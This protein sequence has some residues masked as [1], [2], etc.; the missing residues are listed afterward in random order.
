MKNKI[1]T[2]NF[3]FQNGLLYPH[4]IKWVDE[5]IDSIENETLL[6]F[7]PKDKSALKTPFD[8][9]GAYVLNTRVKIPVS[10]KEWLPVGCQ[11]IH[12]SNSYEEKFVATFKNNAY[13]VLW[14]IH[15]EWKPAGP[16]VY[17]GEIIISNEIQ[18]EVFGAND[19]VTEHKFK[20]IVAHE[21]VHV[22]DI[23]RLVVPAFMDWRSFWKCVLN[24]GSA[25]EDLISYDD[26]VRRF[27]DSYGDIKELER[28]EEYW[29]SQAKKWFDAFRK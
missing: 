23:M 5:V 8:E 27:V 21:L 25:C 15:A 2:R 9:T 7:D 11:H 13:Q 26:D 14:P 18:N 1:K 17:L 19:I 28:I 20:C 4:V 10:I 29:P 24:E 12:Y 6:V 3:K 22:F 16:A